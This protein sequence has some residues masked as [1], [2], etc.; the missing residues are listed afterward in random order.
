MDK[1]TFRFST[2]SVNYF[3]GSG[4]SQLKEVVDT[5]N[6]IILTDENVFTAHAKRFK[7]W[8]TIVLKPGEEFKVQGTVDSV[9]EQL[10][11]MGADRQTTLIGVGGGVITDLTGYI[12]SIY[13]RG[14]SFGFIP[15]TLLSLVDASIGGKN[16]IDV[17]VYK[18]LV[19]AI[20]QPAFILQDLQFLNTLPETE[21]QNGFAEIIKHAC[22]KDAPMFRQLESHD[23]K[24]YIKNKREASSLI[25][26]NVLIKTKVV[27][28]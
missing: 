19:G 22:I 3:F 10:I 6:S 4:M 16:G 17:G 1:K 11:E 25:R 28:Q 27:M 20:K 8:N 15:T 2:S 18:N 26:R 7:N 12:A 13:M 23:L 24:F 9:I 14:I 21:W 5:K